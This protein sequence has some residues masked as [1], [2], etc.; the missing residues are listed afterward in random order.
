MPKYYFIFIFLCATFTIKGQTGGYS[1]SRMDSLFNSGNLELCRL[2]C[3]RVLFFS[4]DAMAHRRA[5]VLKALV[6]K[7]TDQYQKA[8]EDLQQIRIFSTTDTLLPFKAYHLALCYYLTGDNENVLAALLPLE[9]LPDTT[10]LMPEALLL[11]ALALNNLKQHQQAKSVLLKLSE[12]PGNQHKKEDFA[13]KVQSL[14]HKREVPRTL[15][16]ELAKNMSMIIPGSGHIY[17][18]RPVEGSI[19]FLLNASALAFGG[20]HIYQG[21]YFTGYV[22]GFSLLHKFHT[23]GMRRSEILADTR[24]KE[25]QARFNDRV[26]QI[27]DQNK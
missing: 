9:H 27:F 24:N 4:T 8:I 22:I 10:Q 3:N 15:N 7:Q 16:P 2:E 23:G 12:L 17:A 26:V 19:S 18:G 6:S 20:Y 1:L 25:K 13:N 14:Y 21:Y 5:M 11:K